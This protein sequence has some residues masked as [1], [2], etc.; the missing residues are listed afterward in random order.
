VAH[1]EKPG[2]GADS[3]VLGKDAGIFERHIPA[4][5]IDHFGAQAA[6]NRIQSGF[7][8]LSGGGR[9]H[10]GY[11]KMGTK[12]RSMRILECQ[13]MQASRVAEKAPSI[14]AFLGWA[15]PNWPA[16]CLEGRLLARQ[17]YAANLLVGH[18]TLS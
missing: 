2:T 4:A 11:L 7:S 8:E 10:E 14:S 3:L 1:V 17:L 12:N 18:A 5:E 9:S 16:V 13:Q 15:R 6:M